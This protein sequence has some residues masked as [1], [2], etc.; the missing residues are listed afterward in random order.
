MPDPSKYSKSQ[1]RTSSLFCFVFRSNDTKT[2]CKFSGNPFIRETS[3][4]ARNLLTFRLST[5]AR[6][7]SCGPTRKSILHRTQ[8]LVE[9]NSS[10]TW[11]RMP[12][13]FSKSQQAGNVSHNDRRGG[14]RDLQVTWVHHCT[15]DNNVRTLQA[16]QV[17]CAPRPSHCKRT[18]KSMV[19]S[20]LRQV[21]RRDERPMC[22]YHR[23]RATIRKKERKKER[24]TQTSAGKQLP[25]LPS[26]LALGGPQDFSTPASIDSALTR[27]SA[28]G[29]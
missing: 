18:C 6:R 11:S 20:H 23:K 27:L 14:K 1:K 5:V 28:E 9:T 7:G 4:H 13:S 15:Y 21:N 12:G 17:S 25:A 16:A 19:V 22:R 26:R 3:I 2:V 29:G 24:K 10:D 8:S